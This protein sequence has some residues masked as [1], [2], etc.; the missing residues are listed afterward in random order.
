MREERTRLGLTQGEV[1]DACALQRE[2]WSRYEADKIAPGLEVLAALA[3]L[4]V[5]V[6][7]VLTG[8]RSFVPPD[9]LTAREAV[10]LGNYRNAGA[11]G[12]R[13]I[14]ATA[15]AFAAGAGP[16]APAGADHS[17]H[18]HGPIEA[19]AGRDVRTVYANEPPPPPKRRPPKGGG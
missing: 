1:A 18:Y 15:A 4:S 7:Y 5:D 11:T 6:L 13:T 9:P 3:R 19:I 14:E 12:Q 2:T 16:P 8:S 17:T 10:L